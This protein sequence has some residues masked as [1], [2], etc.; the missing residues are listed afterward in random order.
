LEGWLFGDKGYIST[1]LAE[2]LKN[3]GLELITK[4]KNN[5]QKKV[6]HPVKNLWLKK[7]G[8]VESA[9]D[10]MKAILHIQHTRHRSPDNF[11]VNLLAGILGY[12]FKPKKPTVSFAKTISRM[13]LLRSN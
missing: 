3:R 4:V 11:L 2:E 1:K 8:V 13:A 5:M 6:I 12:I 7:R 9:I 10:Q